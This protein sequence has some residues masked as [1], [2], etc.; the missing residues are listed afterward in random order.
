MATLNRREF[1]R[2][3]GIAS[4]AGAAA[5]SYD[6]KAPA[7]QILPYV[8]QPEDVLPGTATYFSTLCNGCATACGLVARAKEGRVV[9]VEGNPDHPD[10][11]GLCTR[12]HFDLLATYSPDRITQAILAGAPVS[13]DDATTKIV[14]AIKAAQAAGKTVGW[15]GQYR[16]GSVARLLGELSAGIG[17]KRVHW[18]ALGVESVVKAAQQVFGQAVFPSYELA[19]ADVIVSFGH[20]FLGTAFDTMHL[21]KGWAKAKDP[22][23]GGFVTRFVAIEPRVSATSTQADNHFRPVAGTEV[24]VALAL[25]KLVAA[26]KGYTGAAT[27]Q[28]GA[29][30]PGAVATK[31]G[32]GERLEAI[33]GWI[34]EAKRS[35]VLPGGPSNQ[36]ADGTALAVATF[37]LNEVAGNV[38]TSV[39]LTRTSRPG[40]V[41]SYADAKA[42]LEDARAGK[43]GVLFLD[44]ADPAFSFP[45]SDKAAEALAAVDLVVHLDNEG[46]DSTPEKALLL[47]VG[48]GLETWGDAN[49]VGGV[50][51]LQQP[52][53]TALHDVRAVGDVVLAVG[54]ALGVT[55]AVAKPADEEPAEVEVAATTE[56]AAPVEGAP[57]AETVAGGVAATT[58]AVTDAKATEPSEK[59]KA[60]KAGTDA[61]VAEETPKA[62]ERVP[63]GYGAATFADYVK[64]R[65]RAEIFPKSG[66]ASFDAFWTAS[67]QRGGFFKPRRSA[68]LPG[69]TFASTP[70]AA[71]VASGEGMSLVVFPSPFLADGRHANRPWAQELPDPVSTYTWS[72]WAEISPATV[73][74][75]GLAITDRVS[76]KT[77]AGEIVIPFFQSPG[78]NDDT[79]AVV[80]G[81]GRTR[82]GRYGSGRGANVMAL[83]TSTTDT[84]SGAFA[85]YGAK[86]TVARADGKSKAY[87]ASG[88]GRPL[89]E[90][91]QQGRPL[92]N[93]VTVKEAVE[94]TTGE[95]GSIVH[96]HEIPVDPRL[97]AAGLTDMFPEPQHPTFRFALAFDTNSCNGCMACVVACNLENNIPF[98]GPEQFN[99]GRTMTWIRMDRFWEG[100]GEH[101]DV[102]HLPAL[103]QHCA[104]APCEG[105]CPVLATYHNLDGLNAM[106]YNRC[107]GTRYCANNCPYTARRF[108][109]H[110]WEWPES[111]HLMLNPDVSVREMGVME[112]CTFCV[113]RTRAAKDAWRD[114]AFESRED[115]KPVTITT[116]PDSALVGLTA[117]AAACPTGSI[118]FGNAKDEAGTVAKKF[119][120]PRAYTLLGELNTKPGVR[121]LARVRHDFTPSVGHHAASGNDHEAT[122][123][124]GGDATG[125]PAGEHGAGHKEG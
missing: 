2:N 115:G 8:N 11:P 50:H 61:S 7:E 70:A 120:S 9:M 97:K 41:N 79:V 87:A 65:W 78:V 91:D 52:A 71:P 25:A 60:E 67:L 6:P 113:Q 4:A 106:I 63:M 5:C 116:V 89:G 29:V 40:Q 105:V 69:A 37:L 46:S 121:Y 123:H 20:D 26:K 84:A 103:C 101:Q 108:N 82:A 111:M 75:L 57:A 109:Y 62:D 85:F 54:R 99:R 73:K 13:W 76:V 74:K 12:G 32:L 10:G 34:A 51:V 72:T 68:V 3:V 98:V 36:G 18:E 117:C 95:A 53:M 86:A 16:T 112:K 47:P 80:F 118:T 49:V 110:T 38:G 119:A 124:E 88:P 33:A 48:T 45:A 30:D 43:V 23:H 77:A 125:A 81:N 55:V 93:V 107:V 92:A 102:R 31:S 59:E 44:G 35:V 17:M 22:S 27:A 24:D 15:L 94:H 104:H 64:A 39:S 122:G 100:D 21:A 114:V 96:L 90:M 1:L 19:D 83:L 56:T 66:E 14:E 42:L 58:A 28:L